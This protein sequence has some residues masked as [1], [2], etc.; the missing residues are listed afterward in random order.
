[1]LVKRGPNSSKY[2]VIWTAN[3]SKKNIVVIFAVIGVLLLASG[4]LFKKIIVNEVFEWA[5][6]RAFLAVDSTQSLSQAMSQAPLNYINSKDLPKIVIDIKFKHIQKILD[7]R[8][9]ALKKGLLV[10]GGKDFVPASIRVG[11]RDVKVK[12]R[13]KG[14]FTDHLKGDKWSFRVKTKGK[15][16]LFGMRRFSL[17]HPKVRGYQLEPL[18]FEQLRIIGVLAPRY[19]FVNVVINGRDIG[20]M[21]VEEHFSKEILEANARKE[22]VIFRFNEDLAFDARD[23]F[24]KRMGLSGT[25][26]SYKNAKIDAFRSGKI[27]KSDR[28]KRDYSYAVGLLRAF[29][30]GL[31][32]AS[33]VFEAEMLGKLFAAADIWG[34][35]HALEWRNI[36]FYLNPWT[37][38][39]EPIAY[40]ANHDDRKPIGQ[41]ATLKSPWVKDALQDELVLHEYKKAMRSILD[42]LSSGDFRQQLQQKEKELLSGLHKEFYLLAGMD[43]AYFEE[44]RKFV[45]DDH[46]LDQLDNDDYKKVELS[47]TQKLLTKEKVQKNWYPEIFHAY[48]LNGNFH[49]LELANA[50]PFDISISKIKIWKKTRN[51][52]KGQKIDVSKLEELLPLKLAATPILDAPSYKTIKLDFLDSNQEYIIS[53]KGSIDGYDFKYSRKADYYFPSLAESAVPKSSLD[54]ELNK[55]SF[56]KL[57]PDKATLIIPEGEWQVN[58]N[59]IIPKG[60]QLQIDAGAKLFFGKNNLLLVNGAVKLRGTKEKP[61]VLT[62]KGETWQ[63]MTVMEAKEKSTIDYS[64]VENTT[65]IKWNGW[66][67]TGG[68]TFYKSDVDINNGSF[69]GNKGEDALNIIHSKFFI[70]D[71]LIKD[72]ASDAFDADFADGKFLDGKFSN[73]GLLG[74]G[75]GI[76]VSGSEIIVEGTIL[77]NIDDKAISVGEASRM[78]V[79]NVI[80]REVGTGAAS[81]DGSMLDISDSEIDGVKTAALM[82]YIKKPE[83]SAAKILAKN[84]NFVGSTNRARVQLG[85]V[86]IVDDVEIPTENINVKDMYKTIM[87]PGLRR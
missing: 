6:K 70:R 45:L 82:A 35:W 84:I 11:D 55:N 72:T 67:L 19:F 80:V 34:S 62:S 54:V 21:A 22:G 56:I 4:L 74:G 87:K 16:H 77:E 76:D 2:S 23:G 44:Q 43:Y 41:F 85:N 57:L 18:F 50:I 53:V 68:V 5:N 29:S 8:N 40:D 83:Y 69:V 86:I 17:Q 71:V 30:E 73:I 79:K 81:K 60:F 39:L 75:D 42:M 14:D 47:E 13:L 61:V 33:E 1:M 64:Q 20:V 63:G 15:G 3:I 48:L 27:E 10:Q 49:T 25:F 38:K 78:R 59:I 52:R 7:K 9:E 31:K 24:E 65:G 26:D 28:L 58:S 36:R 66:Q 12:L 51:N 46:Y 37:M 32:P